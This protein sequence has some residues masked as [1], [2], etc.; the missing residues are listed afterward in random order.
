MSRLRLIRYAKLAACVGGCVTF[1]AC[2]RPPQPAQ[3]KQPAEFRRE[4]FD[5]TGRINNYLAAQ[6]P[7]NTPRAELRDAV[8]A[9][10]HEYAMIAGEARPLRGKTGDEAYAIIA[11]RCDDGVIV[12]G[13]LASALAANPAKHPEAYAELAAAIREWK[14]FNDDLAGMES[15]EA[16]RFKPRPWWEDPAWREATG[17]NVVPEP[18]TR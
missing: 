9:L 7:S 17:V 8:G 16:D 13:N 14:E 2:A 6:N 4:V 1:V 11:S 3:I 18:K 15:G 12:A 10:A 5:V